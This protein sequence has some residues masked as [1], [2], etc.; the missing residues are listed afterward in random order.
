MH[1]GRYLDLIVWLWT[2]EYVS[3][4]WRNPVPVLVCRDEVVDPPELFY[5]L[6]QVS[7][8][9]KIGSGHDLHLPSFRSKR[10]AVSNISQRM[11]LVTTSPELYAE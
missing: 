8:L 9:R 11:D 4:D 1:L 7:L 10:N 3:G 5:V 2:R 6:G